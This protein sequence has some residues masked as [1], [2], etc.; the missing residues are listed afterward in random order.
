MGENTDSQIRVALLDLQNRAPLNEML[1]DRRLRITRR[2]DIANNKIPND[3]AR[4]LAEVWLPW[5]TQDEEFTS[6]RLTKQAISGQ[7]DQPYRKPV[8]EP[9]F[10][11]RVF[12][13]IPANDRVMVGEPGV[14]YDQYGR[15]IVV[16]NYVQFS[17][18]TAIYSTDP[19]TT[20]APAPN[21]DCVL[22]SVDSSNDGTL[23]TSKETFIDSGVL[24]DNEELKFDGKL[25]LR[26]IRS[27]N[28]IPATPAGY[29]L[30]TTSTEYV[31]GLPVYSYGFAAGGGGGGTGTGG[32]ISREISYGQ[33]IDEGVNGTTL[34]TIDYLTDS[35]VAVNPITPP[36]GTVLIDVKYADETGYRLWTAKYAKGAGT[37]DLGTSIQEGGV[38]YIYRKV[39]LGVA[40]TAPSASIGGTVTL[41]STDVRN[42]DGYVVYDYQWAE[43]NGVV[44]EETTY[45]QSSD[46]GTTGVTIT[47]IRQ[48]SALSVGTSPITPPGGMAL[49]NVGYVDANGYRVWT[50]RWASGTG[51][52]DST[53]EE[54]DGGTLIIY[55]IV[56]LGAAPSAPAPT[57]GGTV[58]ATSE[59]VSEDNGYQVFTYT[60]AEGNGLNVDDSTV[61]E[62][63][64]LVVYRRRAYGAA[65]STPSAT[66]GGTVTLIATDVTQ[67]EGYVIYDYRWAE[68]DGQSSIQVQG[69]ADGALVYV[70]TDFNAGSATPAYPGSGTAYLIS[71]TNK[72]EAGFYRNTAVY[73]K[74][75]ADRTF[76]KQ[77]QFRMPGLAAFVGT[78]PQL[79][80]SS[81]VSMDILADVEVTYDTAQDTTTPFTVEAY[82][83][84]YYNYIV[85]ATGQPVSSTDALGGYL[86]GASSISGTNDFFNGVLCEEYEAVLISSIPSSRPSG[87]TVISVD[88]DPYLTA[89]DGTMVFRRT[90]VS[91]SF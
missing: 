24:A 16:I 61:S 34:Y 65:P 29:T 73:K 56:A 47:T 78:P 70:V 2:Y 18:G 31:E 49:V 55:R 19:G 21:N 85:S 30:V 43:G 38:L 26:T 36:A 40:P 57:I 22:Q 14:S 33:S 71:L 72:P 53:T 88:N 66:I 3:P 17:A 83:S 89:T 11:T 52:V 20:T 25:K 37:V 81:P 63:G 54:R 69:E 91:Y 48:L 27:L 60:W 62:S 46:E 23:I 41:I 13:E 67:G 9:P 79:T 44:S 15:K 59:K 80:I 7:N 12:E 4:M 32:E 84:L 8:E 90:V 45:Q 86:A 42:A 75:P 64:S 35:S 87:P 76:S 58:T 82:A 77:T 28:E 6:C 1:P 51:T 39:G 74:P 68:G 10:L 5:G 50:G